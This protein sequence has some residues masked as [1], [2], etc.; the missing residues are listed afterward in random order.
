[1]LIEMSP[2]V[3]VWVEP[4]ALGALFWQ[5]FAAIAIGGIVVV[6]VFAIIEPGPL[7]KKRP[8]PRKRRSAQGNV[9]REEGEAPERGEQSKP[10]DRMK[11]SDQSSAA[12]RVVKPGVE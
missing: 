2:I 8:F 1:M 5:V 7:V 6:V 9:G 11:S 4:G 3:T 10:A 12:T